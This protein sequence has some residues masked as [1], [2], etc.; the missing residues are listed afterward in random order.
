MINS[1]ESRKYNKEGASLSVTMT[2]QNVKIG[3]L[4]IL[5]LV[6]V[7]L[8]SGLPFG[9]GSLVFVLKEEG[10][11]SDLCGYRTNDSVVLSSSLTDTPNVTIYIER[12]TPSL[13]RKKY[14]VNSSS[15]ILIP[16]DDNNLVSCT[17]QNDRLNLL[18]SIGVA[19]LTVFD[20][21]SGLVNQRF[22]NTKTRLF[23]I[24]LFAIG[25]LSTAFASTDIPWLIL[26]GIILTGIGGFA[27]VITNIRIT[28]F[29]TQGSSIYI[30][31]LN[32]CYDSSASVQII[33]K[34]L[35]EKGLSRRYTYIGIMVLQIVVSGFITFLHYITKEPSTP[36][37]KDYDIKLDQ[38]KF[39][40]AEEENLFKEEMTVMKNEKKEEVKDVLLSTRFIFHLAWM[41]ILVLRFYYFVGSIN[42]HLEKNLS[43]TRE[44]GYFTNILAYVMFGGLISSVIAGLFC[45]WQQR[46]FKDNKSELKRKLLPVIVPLVLTSC[47]N[48]LLSGLAFSNVSSLLYLTFIVMVFLRSF[49]YCVNMQYFVSTFPAKYS[50]LIFGS[51]LSLAGVFSMAQYALFI[52]GD[53]YPNAI[54]HVNILLLCL[55]CISLLHP[56]NIFVQS[57]RH[58]SE[59]IQHK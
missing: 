32:G 18:F 42:A 45:E 22:G 57:R 39:P 1:K 44:V 23:F 36:V 29:L 9:W 34:Y 4:V 35:Y 11:Y 51:E 49:M 7:I 41:S 17:A 12:S 3:L 28:S 40:S 14:S 54:N 6:E 33:V 19:V 43:S 48:L 20:F 27:L 5:S 25:A 31:F 13:N 15:G 16:K 2:T 53:A 55:A 30:G 24:V 58:N 8:F 10:V 38:D 46:I 37:F 21:S 52:W 26:P 50:T 47:L 59:D 56:I